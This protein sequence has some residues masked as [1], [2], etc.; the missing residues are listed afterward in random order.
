MQDDVFGGRTAA[1]AAEAV[2]RC[3]ALGRFSEIEDGVYRPFG[4]QS[5]EDAARLVER[6]MADAGLDVRR[7]AFGTVVGRRR[8]VGPGRRT[9]YVG[10]H[11]DTVPDGGLYDGALGVVLPIVLCKALAG[12]ALPFDLCVLG[13]LAEEGCRFGAGCMS[14]RSLTGRLDRALLER[15]APDGTTLA[16][17]VRFHGGQ[18]ERVGQ[19]A[20]FARALGYVE[21]H[22]E[23]ASVLDRRRHSVGVVEGIVGQSRLSLTF[24]GQADHAGTTE[25][26]DRRDALCAAADFVLAV[27]ELAKADRELFATVGRLDVSPNANNV[28]P[29]AVSLSLDVRHPHDVARE[30]ALSALAEAARAAGGRRGVSVGW[31][32]DGQRAAATCDAGLMRL[33]GEAVRAAGV[34]EV[35][36]PSR[37][38]HDAMVAARVM[39]MAMLFVRSPGG[40][41]HHPDER[42]D[43]ADVAVAVDVMGRFF[44]RLARQ[45]AARAPGAPASPYEETRAP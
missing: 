11:L 36:L 25:M 38:G 27:E 30:V 15:T 9:L 10:S 29:G 43:V 17:A 21:V 4:R 20:D 8:G 45:E 1:L 19:A 44:A 22:I 31:R 24:T 16:E 18:P 33:L 5:L 7:D 37:A 40:L 32:I 3:H 6:W 23:Q 13:F 26:G 34:P 14:A 39:P 28:I 35:R 41:S 12:R 42:L 2:A